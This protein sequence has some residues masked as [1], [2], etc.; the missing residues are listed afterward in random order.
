MKSLDYCEQ[1]K[2]SVEDLLTLEH[3]QTKG[4]LRRRVRFLRLLKSGECQSQAK[5]GRRIGIER[6]QSEKLWARYRKEGLGPLLLYPFTGHQERLNEHQKQGLDKKLRADEI[7]TLSQGQQY[8][9]QHEQLHYSLSGVHY[10]FK[11]LKVKKKTGRP[12][13]AH[14]D[15]EGAEA[16]K[17]KSAPAQ[18]KL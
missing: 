8:L 16:F 17:K 3:K 13:H 1:I 7:Q 18:A 2:E 9:E 10:L 11:R 4:L 14:R 12:V 15:N 6:R 5:A